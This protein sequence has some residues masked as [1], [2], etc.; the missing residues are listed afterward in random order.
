[1]RRRGKEIIPLV[2]IYMKSVK[3][4]LESME[5]KEDREEIERGWIEFLKHAGVLF[6][7]DIEYHQRSYNHI[8]FS[9]GDWAEW[10]SD[11]DPNKY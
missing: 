6:K 9:F 1:L 4:G 11:Y 7:I 3:K 5:F 10:A 8:F 2:G